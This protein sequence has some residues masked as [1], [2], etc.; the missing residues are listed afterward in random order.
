MC[1]F[2]VVCSLVPSVLVIWGLVFVFVLC[3]ESCLSFI[4]YSLLF[5]VCRLF[6]FVCVLF[7]MCHTLPSQP[8]SLVVSY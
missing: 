8:L 5:V 3:V 4:V 6:V 7:V 1:L 2:V